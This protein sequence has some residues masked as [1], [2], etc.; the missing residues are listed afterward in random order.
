[1]DNNR[2]TALEIYKNGYRDRFYSKETPQSKI[3]FIKLR[4][5]IVRELETMGFCELLDYI[6]DSRKGLID[7]VVFSAFADIESGYEKQKMTDVEN[8]PKYYEYIPHVKGSRMTALRWSDC[9]GR[10]ERCITLNEGTLEIFRK[11]RQ[12]VR[13]KHLKKI[14]CDIH[15]AHNGVVD[16]VNNE[17]K[18]AN[19][20]VEDAK[21][22]A[23][24]IINESKREAERITECAKA[25]A[26]T[27]INEA[28]SEANKKAGKFADKLIASYLASEQKQFKDDLNEELSKH[29]ATILEASKRTATTHAEMCDATNA[30]QVK[31]V[32]ALDDA[33][34]QMTA[35]KAEFYAHLHNWQVSLFPSEIKPLAE[36]Y[37]ELYRIINVDKLVREAILLQ[38]ETYADS[39]QT[40]N[41]DGSE[42][43]TESRE[44]SLSTVITGLQKL[45]KTLTT[46]LRRFEVALNGLDLYVFY[47]NVGDEFDDMWHIPDDEEEE[48]YG[49][50][51][52][53]CV[54]PGIAKK[55]NDDCGD[56]VL[57][58]AVVKV[59]MEN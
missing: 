53:E 27:I 2:E 26:S 54:V 59:E 28:N 17:Q 46:F 16:S 23:E 50:R 21:R 14:E 52:K 55:A 12:I 32:H 38:K 6:L 56:D 25:S 41:S 33:L 30:L 36:R 7:L 34:A 29:S 15:T 3:F 44:E 40:G 42:S 1:M 43:A 22:K 11:A 20:I 37:L 5:A 13:A 39:I 51:I 8:D 48:Y 49:K 31:W 18:E 24:R 35:I 47:P 19:Q 9:N 4:S 45:N 10:D 58:P 57:I